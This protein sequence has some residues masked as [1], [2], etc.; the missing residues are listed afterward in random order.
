MRG[1]SPFYHHQ[2]SIEMTAKENVV[3]FYD[4][5][6]KQQSDI[7]VPIKS[8]SFKKRLYEVTDDAGKIVCPNHLEH[9]FRGFEGKFSEF[10]GRLERKAF[11]EDNYRTNCFL[12]GEEK[13]FW[14]TYIL[15]QML[16]DPF[17]L[18][19]VESA[20]KEYWK[21][22]VDDIK[23]RNAARALCLP[24][25]GEISSDSPEAMVFNSVL[26]RMLSMSFSVGVDLSGYL[27]TSDRAYYAQAD[28]MPF[29]EC[30]RII[31]PVTSKICLILHGGKKKKRTR[32]NY[33][34]PIDDTTRKEIFCSIAYAASE[35]IYANHKLCEDELKMLEMVS[36]D[37]IIDGI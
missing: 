17:L 8:I 24:F 31:F 4:I 34:F 28:T 6:Y 5:K 14:L 7:A 9:V 25:F 26:D 15:V 23:A 37:R 33:L 13:R 30:E 27:I 16:R 29:E 20:I 22:D 12:D 36:C 2:S 21:D 11:F 18:E 35:K 19:E 1:F 32:K 10:R 3:Y